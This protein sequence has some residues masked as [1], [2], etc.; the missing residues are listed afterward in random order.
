MTI[1]SPG[2]IQP[3]AMLAVMWATLAKMPYAVILG[4]AMLAGMCDLLKGFA[5]VRARVS[6]VRSPQSR[7]SRNA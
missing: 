2:T 6:A 4:C 5:I 3:I 1:F 7:N